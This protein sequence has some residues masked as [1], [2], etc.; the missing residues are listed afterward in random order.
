MKR[1]PLA[2]LTLGL[3][4]LPSQ[5]FAQ[6]L[7]S[8]AEPRA[9]VHTAETLIFRLT[10][11]PFVLVDGAGRVLGTHSRGDGPVKPVSEQEI[12]ET[13]QASQL[14]SE[15]GAALWA[16]LADLD[17]ASVVTLPIVKSLVAASATPKAREALYSELAGLARAFS[18][19]D[20]SR[21]RERSLLG[22][23]ERHRSA[24]RPLFLELRETEASCDEMITL[25]LSSRVFGADLDESVS[26]VSERIPAAVARRI[27]REREL[28]RSA[29]WEYAAFESMVRWKDARLVPGAARAP[30]S[31]NELD[32]AGAS[33]V[34]IFN[35]L[36]AVDVGFREVILRGLGPVELFNAVVAG[37]N[38]LYRLGTS[39][40]R[41]FLHAIILRGIRESGSF[42]AFLARAVPRQL[43]DEAIRAADHRG[44]VFLR[45][46]ASFGLLEL[47]LETVRDRD[48]FIGDAIASLGD[49]RS[50]EGNSSVVMDLLTAQSDSP[51]VL[52]FKGLLLDRLYE[53]Y[54]IERRASLQTVYGSMLSVYQTVTGNRRDSAIDRDFPL[55]SAVFRIPFERLFSPDGSGGFAHRMFMRMDENE[56]A[57]GTYAAFRG[58]VMSLG[59]SVRDER[60]YEV[61]RFAAP[62]R[63]IEIY[64][65]KP[66]AAGIRQGIA[67]IAD[68]LRGSRVET[69]IGRGH[70]SI[71]A[72][73]QVDAK[74]V[75]GNRVKEVATVIVGSCGGD[76]SVRELITTFG[77]IPYLTT[78]STGR[79]LINNAIMK[80]YIAALMALPQDASLA[81]VDVL[82][83]ALERFMGAGVDEATRTDASLYQVNMT[84]VLTALLFDA[85]V[86]RHTEPGLHA[87]GD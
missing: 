83:R 21:S 32:A 12:I 7:R 24:L 48:R 70:T 81:M 18:R 5:S 14:T 36:H 53:R 31:L 63:A 25:M 23:F 64:A 35:C 47:L 1:G 73:L 11:Q 46:V 54:R 30:R 45:V 40:Y 38:E 66:S 15:H 34:T 60:Y 39:G 9:E 80:S 72:P 65:N 56:D 79:Q 29:R 41:G 33:F 77:Y 75:L 67:D 85:H 76:A 22:L 55:D 51:A 50:F 49:P 19:N 84:T 27:E 16:F 6:E 17:N 10:Q 74:R 43:G 78:K 87:A 42:E 13:L 52:A 26:Y 20:P 57:V 58:L 69:V 4:A 82:D 61:F 68:A 37:E 44:M 59:A 2:A 86:R 28:G 71:I 3:V 62:G 8:Q